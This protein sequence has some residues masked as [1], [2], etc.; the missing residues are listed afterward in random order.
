MRGWIQFDRADDLGSHHMVEGSSHELAQ[1]YTKGPLPRRP[2]DGDSYYIIS[3]VED[4]Q[5]HRFTVLFHFFIAY[6]EALA[7]LGFKEALAQLGHKEGFSQV[8]L[9]L[10]DEE[11]G[12]NE[13]YVSMA[14][15]LNDDEIKQAEKTPSNS[16]ELYIQTPLGNLSG[17]ADC[18]RLEARLLQADQAP[19]DKYNAK[20]CK[21]ELTMKDRGLPL[22]YLATGIIPFAGDIDYEYALPD[23]DTS[24]TLTFGNNTYQVSGTSWFDREWGYFGRCKW[25]W[26][27][28]ELSNGGRI[29]LWAQ[30]N[31]NDHPQRFAEGQSAFATLLES[32]GS[33]TVASVSVQEVESFNI[34]QSLRRYPRR[35]M[36][37]I[38][39]KQIELRVE[40]LRNGQ[41]IIPREEISSG[42]LC[43]PR[44]EG[45][46]SVQGT[47]EGYE[48]EGNAFVE[49]FNLFPAFDVLR[50]AESRAKSAPHVRKND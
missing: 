31:N 44:L 21:I 30:Q 2:A 40:L 42:N 49:C 37:A 18:I 41:E 22:P 7:A 12:G 33:I 26:M 50:D 11:G 47:Y 16:P 34:P 27:A 38:P 20:E 13:G 48:V 15:Q 3:Y 8:A 10:L 19:T 32:R 1:G 5:G 9:S 29:A 45:K 17:T 36:V 35:W 23:M 46:A 14:R 6:K 25:T 24:G 28:I 39:A 43:T 4:K